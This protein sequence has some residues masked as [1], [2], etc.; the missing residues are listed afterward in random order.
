MNQIR[1]NRADTHSTSGFWRRFFA[2]LAHKRK[3]VELRWDLTS[4]KQDRNRFKFSPTGL[5]LS[6]PFETVLL[7]TQYEML[8]AA[9]WTR[10]VC[11]RGYCIV[12]SD[13]PLHCPSWRIRV[14]GAQAFFTPAALCRERERVKMMSGGRR[15]A[16]IMNHLVLALLH[17]LPPVTV[18]NL[19]VPPIRSA[20]RDREPALPESLKITSLLSRGHLVLSA[21]INPIIR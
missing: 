7:H 13:C 14:S 19:A 8:R 6:I 10:C 11:L 9:H 18:L 12:D 4:G 2:R 20:Q 21:N 3:D 1:H 15:L 16:L 17:L 5:C